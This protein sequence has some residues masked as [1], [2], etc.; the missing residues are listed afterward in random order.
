M[1]EP[2]TVAELKDHLRVTAAD[3]DTYL[4]TLITA[5]RQH[6]EDRTGRA[7]K[8]A[9]VIAKLH[10]FPDGCSYIELPRTP[11]RSVASVAYLDEDGASQT[12]DAENYS[13]D[14]D[15][16]PGQLWLAYDVDWPT[17]REVDNAVTITYGAGYLTAALIPD[18]IKMACLWAAGWWYE[19]RLPVNIG[20]IV[21]PLRHHLESL[22]WGAR[23][24]PQHPEH[25]VSA[26][27]QSV[28][29][30]E[31]AAGFYLLSTI[32]GLTGGT[33]TDLDSLE[34]VDG[35]TY[36]SGSVVV[37]TYSDT[38]QHWLLRAGTNAENATGGI[39]RPDDYATS[40]NEKIWVQIQ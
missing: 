7:L 2:I 30:S 27:V 33:A 28:A 32:T 23:V 35:S 11:L 26:A 39:V 17:T 21:N 16:E 12:W 6:I 1:S 22:I 13:V 3:E 4:G 29:A 15:A 31:A 25:I 18:K 40:T 9:T 8:A 5:A 36:G 37:L 19:Q 34:T 14:T 10:A 20:N 24:F 38:E